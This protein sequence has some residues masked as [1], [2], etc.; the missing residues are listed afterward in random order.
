[1]QALQIHPGA[2]KPSPLHYID[3]LKRVQ[4]TGKN[5]HI[6]LP[7][8]EVRPALEQL[9]ARGLFIVTGC[10]TEAE[11]RELLGNAERWSVDRG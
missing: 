8:E 5:L 10:H 1:L 4:A 7:A 2:G 3:V 9:S 11:A 6:T